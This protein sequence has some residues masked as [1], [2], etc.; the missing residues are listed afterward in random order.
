[1]E[2]GD[3]Q[4]YNEFKDGKKSG[5]TAADQKANQQAMDAADVMVNQDTARFAAYNQAEQKLVNDVAWLPL[6]QSPT[7]RLRK[8][9]VVGITPNAIGEIPPWAWANV[10]IAAH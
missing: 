7:A 6:Y 1:M 3:N 10:Y 8:P 9:Y 5:A 2:V 4:G